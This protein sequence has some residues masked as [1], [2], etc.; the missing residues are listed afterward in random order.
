MRSPTT[1]ACHGSYDQA[2]TGSG[3]TTSMCPCTIRD[4]PPPDPFWI[5]ATFGRPGNGTPLSPAF[6]SDLIESSRSQTSTASPDDLR[7]SATYDWTFA[8][9]PSGLG[10]RTSSATVSASSS[11]RWSIS[12]QRRSIAW[13]VDSG[14]VIGSPVSTSPPASAAPRHRAPPSDPLQPEL[15]VAPADLTLS[16]K[17]V[18]SFVSDFR[19]GCEAT[20]AV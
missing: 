7:C 12:A 1:V 20:L 16:P 18:T 8:S 6:G 13:R 10:C 14:S 9:A 11:W 15:L 3:E 19:G 17:D 5:P 4:L 2:A